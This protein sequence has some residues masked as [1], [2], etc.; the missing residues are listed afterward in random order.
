MYVQGNEGRKETTNPQCE[1]KQRPQK[2]RLLR[3]RKELHDLELA[4]GRRLRNTKSAKLRLLR[5]Q[6]IQATKPDKAK[7]QGLNVYCRKG[8]TY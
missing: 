4:Q 7:W 3:E 6:D 1:E 5:Y 8:L 2:L